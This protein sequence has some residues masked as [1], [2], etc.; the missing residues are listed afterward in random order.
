MYAVGKVVNGHHFVAI[1]QEG[2]DAVRPDVAATPGHQDGAL[3][4]L[5]KSVLHFSA[6]QSLSLIGT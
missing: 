2:Q 5:G 4:L 3:E 6:T 1:L